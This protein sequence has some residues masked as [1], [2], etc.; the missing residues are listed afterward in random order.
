MFLC[1][2]QKFKMAAKKAGK[3][4]QDKCI[5]AFHAEIQ[6]SD[7]NWWKLFFLL[8]KMADASAYILQAKNCVQI[9]LSHTISKINV[10][11]SFTQFAKK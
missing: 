3:C 2:K 5:F 10:F 7:Q 8:Q 11:L 9:A 1:F 6:D 4:F